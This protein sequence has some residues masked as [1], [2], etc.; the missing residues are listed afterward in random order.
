[1]NPRTILAFLHDTIATIVAWLLAL[2]LRFNFDMPEEN[3]TAALQALVWVVPVYA[4][5]FQYFGLYRGLWRFA[6]LSDLQRILQAVASCAMFLTAVIV[7][8]SIPLIPRS[9][10]VLHPI[11]LVLMMGGS[12]F[13]YR[14]WKERKLYGELRW[15]GDPVL[16][17]GSGEAAATL[18]RDLIRSTEWRV[19][20]LLDD[21]LR[22]HNMLIHGVRILGAI[23][24]VADFARRYG[25]KHVIVAMPSARPADRR[26]AVELASAAG[27][28]VLTVPS[29]DD[30]LSRR[31]S[32]SE[33][34]KVELEDLLGREQV[35]LDND[36]LHHL[37]G[38]KTILIT[39]AGG[40]IG[41]ELARQLTRFN[42]GHLVLFDIGEFALYNIEQEFSRCGQLIRMS[43]VIGDV[44]NEGRLEEVFQR[45]K[46]IIVFHAAAYKHVPLMESDNAWEA[47][48][49][50]VRG[51][52]AVAQT[53]KRHGAAKFVLVS[54]DKAVNPTNV[55]GASKRL[56][57]IVC[58]HVGADGATAFIGVRFGNVLGSNG[59]VIPKFREQIAAGGPVTV[60]HPDIIRYFMSIPEAAQLVL[61]AGL[62][63]QGGEVFV[64]DMGE[65]VKIADLARDMIRLSGLSEQDIRIEFVGLR[66]GEKL[67]EELLADNEHTLPT[68][69]PK[70][71]IAQAAGDARTSKD[72]DDL[73]DWLV[74]AQSRSDD[75]VRARLA[76]FVPEYRPSTRG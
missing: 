26:R 74:S 11:L 71:R 67:F 15:K 73:C 30:I 28:A 64:L 37:V 21:D 2:W 23:V 52:L 72:F 66:P 47:V 54:T 35:V 39:G 40:S 14:A 51:T 62:M 19:F 60:T 22:K 8:F 70:L 53:A 48:Q 63:G 6:S 5:G 44:R 68:P 17:L 18:V 1:M 42:P 24:N 7:V 59:S 43:Y 41:S 4:I 76:A 46:P 9:M 31:V 16:V 36:G 38:G 13:A 49:N 75:A 29:L 20:G 65:P 57:E 32:I 33:V 45:F 12:R 34:R 61:Q 25:V 27:L 50:N 55:M 69:H 56:A 3:V 10:S 58:R